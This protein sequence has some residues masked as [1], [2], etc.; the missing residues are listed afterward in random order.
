MINGVGTSIGSKNMAISPRKFPL[1]NTKPL[2]NAFALNVKTLSSVSHIGHGW[3]QVLAAAILLMH[4]CF[5]ETI[6][7]GRNRKE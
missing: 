3:N 5:S 1:K 6:F 2:S 7:D 4:F